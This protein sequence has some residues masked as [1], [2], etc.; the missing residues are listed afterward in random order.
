MMAF[1]ADLGEWL[2]TERYMQH[3]I[4]L[5]ND[6]IIMTLYFV[7]DMV[8][9]AS[10]FVIGASLMLMYRLQGLLLLELSMPLSA[11]YGAFIFLCGLTHLTKTVTLFS[12]IYRL[13]IIVVA[14]TAA[15]SAATAAFTARQMVNAST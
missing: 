8:I 14:A 11:L 13:D 3:A 1:F 4:C 10:Y 7:G 15:V 9:F 2:G 12:G 5:T 6:P